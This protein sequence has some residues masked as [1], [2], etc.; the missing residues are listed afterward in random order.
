MIDFKYTEE[1]NGIITFVNQKGE[2]VKAYSLTELEDYV[3]SL[4]LNISYEHDAIGGTG[5]VCDPN[6]D[7][8]E[9]E[10]T[11]P[12]SNYIDENWYDITEKF[13]T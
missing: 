1:Q 4:D 11:Q 5:M 10:V 12:I 13:Y 7:F 8:V 3:S 9:R 2:A 6:T